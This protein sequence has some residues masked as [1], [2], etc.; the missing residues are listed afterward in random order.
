M[1]LIFSD[2]LIASKQIFNFT[3][4]AHESDGEPI[5]KLSELYIPENPA[6]K[7]RLIDYNKK[8]L[9]A[10]RTKSS[11]LIEEKRKRKMKIKEMHQKLLNYYKTHKP[12][13]LDETELFVSTNNDFMCNFL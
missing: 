2:I 10:E 6:L 11:A 8:N 5:L 12:K 7:K 13:M 4:I 1:Y 9:M 3:P